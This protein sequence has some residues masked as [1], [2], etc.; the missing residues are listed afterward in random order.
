MPSGRA[1]IG[2]PL[3]LPL[4]CSHSLKEQSSVLLE[5]EAERTNR[6][7]G[8]WSESLRKAVQGG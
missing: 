7:D 8:R 6:P 3:E 2:A 1:Y 4:P 5:S